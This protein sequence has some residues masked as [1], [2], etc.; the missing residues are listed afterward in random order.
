MNGKQNDKI[1]M[2][3]KREYPIVSGSCNNILNTISSSPSP[4]SALSIA[5][6]S[7][8]KSSSPNTTCG[9]RNLYVKSPPWPYHGDRSSSRYRTY[10]PRRGFRRIESSI[11]NAVFRLFLDRS[12]TR[13]YFLRVDRSLRWWNRRHCWDKTATSWW[14]VRLSIIRRRSSSGRDSRVGIFFFLLFFLWMLYSGWVVV[15]YLSS[16]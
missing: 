2:K 1:Y 8:P 6:L 13:R 7:L 4:K 16:R 14:E 10:D 5:L 15:G 12:F 11:L 9:D 3:K